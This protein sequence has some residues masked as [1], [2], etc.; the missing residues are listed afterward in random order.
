MEI[1]DG[2]R[3]IG[4][5]DVIDQI[6]LRQHARGTEREPAGVQDGFIA[7]RRDGADIPVR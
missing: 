5:R 7:R 1:R 4:Q 2:R 6:P 3:Q